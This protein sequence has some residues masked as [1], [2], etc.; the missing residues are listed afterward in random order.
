MLSFAQPW[1]LLALAGLAV[2]WLIHRINR[3]QPRPWPFPSIRFLRTMPLPRVGSRTPSDWWLLFLRTLLLAL[4]I[5]GLSGPSCTETVPPDGGKNYLILIDRS[6]SMGGFGIPE[7]LNERIANWVDTT[8]QGSAFR[9]MAFSEQIEGNLGF[10]SSLNATSFK[11]SLAR[12]LDTHPPLP[13]AGRPPEVLQSIAASEGLANLHWV[14][15][16]DFANAEWNPVN[17]ATF[18]N[19]GLTVLPV[20]P[21]IGDANLS[22][23]SVRV[24]PAVG[25]GRLTVT[26]SIQ[27]WSNSNAKGTLRWI[28]D[29]ATSE[30]AFE[31]PAQSNATFAAEIIRPENPKARVELISPLDEF[32]LDNLRYFFAD[33]PP[34]MDVLYFL[35]SE[36]EE[37]DAAEAFF[38]ETAVNANSGSEW[39][40]F[41]AN[42]AGPFSL[43]S[44]VLRRTAA[45][46]APAGQAASA[47]FD[48]TVVAE[49]V[50]EGG[51]LIL[52]LGSEAAQTLS[53]LRDAGLNPPRYEGLQ[54]RGLDPRIRFFPGDLPPESLLQ[55]TFT[56]DSLEDLFL[57][58]IRQFAV[59]EP[60][61]FSR[62]HLQTE[63]GQPLLIEQ[64]V[65]QGRIFLST[66]RW[67]AVQS[68]FPLRASFLPVIR[69]ILNSASPQSSSLRKVAA[70]GNPVEWSQ[71]GVLLEPQGAVEINL[72][73]A[74]MMPARINRETLPGSKGPSRESF[75]S[76]ESFAFGPWLLVAAA[77][78]WL[79]ESLLATHLSRKSNLPR[80]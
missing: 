53:R 34:P 12:F 21:V 9:A 49:Y 69:E 8:P 65:G 39:V 6:A 32:R 36:A 68:D 63:E 62:V 67:D 16:S 29:S 31:V 56:E 24:L 2:P 17:L 43:E 51:C 7:L 23:R 26:S 74:E 50:R 48:W 41:N 35:P 30:T 37:A 76:R 19:A 22:L 28:T 57:I 59:L 58:A 79:V 25:P 64:A 5:L 73:A 54:G 72:A 44:S 55:N 70:T 33:V 3:A 11:N 14:V 75:E 46:F 61:A 60:N 10:E 27:N 15:V 42:P 13:H 78:F 71:P 66:F 47:D 4:L 20:G 77:L 45:L 52:T 80:T 1:F 40:R 38:F 18:E